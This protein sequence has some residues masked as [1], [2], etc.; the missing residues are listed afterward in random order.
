[1]CNGLAI[2]QSCLA[3]SLDFGS[4]IAGV[5]AVAVAAVAARS[6]Y[7]S[8]M[9]QVKATAKATSDQINALRAQEDRQTEKIRER[10]NRNHRYGYG[11]D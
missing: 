1:M 6:A 10:C 4:L 9:E 11:R 2:G 8:A 5:V 3:L 7:R